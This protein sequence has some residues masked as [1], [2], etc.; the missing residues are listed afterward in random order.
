MLLAITEPQPFDESNLY[1][2]YVC[3]MPVEVDASGNAGFGVPV[4]EDPTPGIYACDVV[5]GSANAA[6]TIAIGGHQRIEPTAAGSFWKNWI[7]WI[8]GS[9]N[10]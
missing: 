1:F 4:D 3:R 2:T 7:Q 10:F 5:K 6:F 9:A 8:Y